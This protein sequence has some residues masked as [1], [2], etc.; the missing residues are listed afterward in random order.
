LP[1]WAWIAIAG[2]T[3]L[4]AAAAV[5]L[6]VLAWRMYERRILLRLLVAFQ[7]V[8]AASDGLR[9]VVERLALGD[10]EQ[11]EV[12]ADEP[13]SVERRAL[14]E[15]SAR[16]GLIAEELDVAPMPARFE[17]VAAALADAAFVVGEQS[18]LVADSMVATSALEALGRID[19]A[20]VGAYLEKARSLLTGA[21]EVCGLDDTAVY[22]GG[23]YL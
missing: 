13:D 12:F 21:C 14:A 4:V 3:L 20:L 19:L 6:A 15:L 2:G 1:L 22:G 18:G 5:A 23:L 11:L 16:A 17:P 10:D 9:D 7:G 8:E